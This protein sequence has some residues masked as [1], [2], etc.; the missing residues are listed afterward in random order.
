M[1]VSLSR[2]SLIWFKDRT[3]DTRFTPVPNSVDFFPTKSRSPTF[4]PVLKDAA[5]VSITLVYLIPTL[6]LRSGF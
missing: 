6:L 2:I 4:T 1:Q 5:V 3:A